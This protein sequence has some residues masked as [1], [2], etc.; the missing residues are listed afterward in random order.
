MKIRNYQSLA[1]AAN[2][3][4]V[5]SYQLLDSAE[6]QIIHLLLK[7]EEK[8]RPHIT[9]VDVTFYV[10]QGNPTILIGEE[11]LTVQTDDLIESPKNIIHCIYNNTDEDV[12][13]LVIKT[14]KPVVPTRFVE[15]AVKKEETMKFNVDHE[16]CVGCGACE[17]ACP[18]VFQMKDDKAHVILNPVPADKQDCAKQAEEIC[19]VMA[20]SHE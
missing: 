14:P 16:A 4:G 7:P 1:A 10:L 17:A 3:H 12:R 8:L 6:A 9:P 15:D 2:P 11:T 19:P 5:Q 20:I 18:A 13:V